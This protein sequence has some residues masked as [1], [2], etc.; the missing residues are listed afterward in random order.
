MTLSPQ[1]NSVTVLLSSVMKIFTPVRKRKIYLTL[2]LN[3]AISLKINRGYHHILIRLLSENIDVDGV[4]QNV[5]S[6]VAHC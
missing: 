4:A 2:H 5:A 6:N 3:S 1:A